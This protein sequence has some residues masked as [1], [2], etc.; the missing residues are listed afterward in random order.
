MTAASDNPIAVLHV[1]EPGPLAARLREQGWQVL[2]AENACQLRRLI[3]R[4]RPTAVVLAANGGEESGWLT[5]A[6]LAGMSPRPAV[7]VADP[8]FQPRQ[9]RL[10]RFVG[11]SRINSDSPEAL[12]Q[13][14][15]KL[16]R[17]RVP[18]SFAC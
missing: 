10:A 3:V 13:A 18:C 5:A 4:L 12:A 1:A 14:L 9:D 17:G 8:V 2:A 11:A 6:K 7:F 16:H 15:A